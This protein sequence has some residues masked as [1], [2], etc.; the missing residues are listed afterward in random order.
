MKSQIKIEVQAIVRDKTGKIVKRGPHRRANSLLK[1]F[2]QLL[3]VQMDAGSRTIKTSL[4]VDYSCAPGASNFLLNAPEGIKTY[5]IVVGTTD[6]AVTMADYKLAA[7]AT[8]NWTHGA[9]TVATANPDASTWR[10]EITRVFTNETGAA[11]TLKEVG[12]YARLVSSSHHGCIERTIYTVSVGAGASVT[13]TY[14]ITIT[15]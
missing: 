3:A 13:F 14:Y 2:I 1:A 6:T 4:N 12:I 5:G 15:L 10:I 7:Q 9:V 11:V 8:T